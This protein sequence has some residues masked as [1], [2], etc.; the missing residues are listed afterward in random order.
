[1]ARNTIWK[2]SKKVDIRWEHKHDANKITRV[3]LWVHNFYYSLHSWWFG[4]G[5]CSF[6]QM[7]WVQSLLTTDKDFTLDLT[8]ENGDFS[9]LWTALVLRVSVSQ[10][11]IVCNGVRVCEACDAI[12]K[13]G[14]STAG[15][16]VSA[17][18][19]DIV[20]R[21]YVPYSICTTVQ[22]PA[23][24]NACW[25]SCST[26]EEFQQCSWLEIRACLMS[27]LCWL[28]IRRISLW[29]ENSCQ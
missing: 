1:M 23:S 22:H 4:Y 18:V 12:W 29:V 14:I 11:L 21:Y 5:N 17:T 19:N 10:V 28:E 20:V 25:F 9:Q 15:K 13:Q 6:W 16:C 2:A 8:F 7:Q 26:A 24:L 27:T 3:L